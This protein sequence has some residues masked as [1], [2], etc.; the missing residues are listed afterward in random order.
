[1]LKKI[2]EIKNIGL[3]HNATTNQYAFGKHTLIYAENGR[4]KSTL[5]SVLSSCS[6]GDASLIDKRK[7]VDSSVGEVPEVKFEFLNGL[8]VSFT[9]GR[10]SRQQP[11]LLVFDTDFVER[12]VYSGVQIRPDQRQ[13]LLDFALGSQSISDKRVI[14]EATN[15]A[16][17]A[18]KQIRFTEKELAKYRKDLSLKEF[19]SLP[20]ISD[21]D[22]Q[23]EM[24]QNSLTTAKRSSELQAR[25]TPSFI[26]SP[27]FN[28]T[29]FLN[30]LSQTLQDIEIDAEKKVNSHLARY[31]NGFEDWISKGQ[32]YHND[33]DCPYCGESIK[34]NE[35]IGAYRK[36][37]NKSYID[38]KKKIATLWKNVEVRV[39]DTVVE[40]WM[41]RVEKNQVIIDTWN[42]HLLSNQTTFDKEFALANIRQLQAL[43]SSLASTKQVNPLE[44]IGTEEDRQNISCFS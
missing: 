43:L 14:E 3:F 34:D 10:W 25:A 12:N 31:A 19:I 5:A 28:F 42:E 33:T 29:D 7:T 18:Q 35:I 15:R 32:A 4:G 23:I 11:N 36:H 38:F 26:S 24:L 2:H 6:S 13:N 17:D 20:P 16:S 44:A 40:S 22:Q 27:D 30:I 39:S 41:G 8:Q 1:M 37:F 21:I 9:S